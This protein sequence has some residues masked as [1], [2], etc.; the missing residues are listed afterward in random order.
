MNTQSQ[1]VTLAQAIAEENT[2]SQSVADT[3]VK[4]ADDIMEMLP[5]DLF[6]EV[7]ATPVFILHD[8]EPIQVEGKKALVY[9]DNPNEIISV[10]GSKYRVVQNEEIYAPFCESVIESDLDLE[11][12]MINS[13]F[14]DGGRTLTQLTFPQH[15]VE[16]KDEDKTALQIVTRNSHDGSW[17]FQ[18][19]TGGFRI[20]CANGQVYGDFIN[21]Y[22][23]THTNGFDISSMVDHLTRQ[24]ETF[25]NIGEYWL[26]LQGQTIDQDKA[27]DMILHYLGKKIKDKQAKE[28]ILASERAKTVRGLVESW[29]NY[30]EEMGSNMFAIYNTLTDD[31]SH[32]KADN[33]SVI[34]DSQKRLLK[35]MKEFS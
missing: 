9:A 2:M 29:G 34:F 30:K 26:T 32:K 18:V 8:E 13:S 17:K 27:T 15:M 25:Q 35:T 16:M 3:S 10:V 5:K 31:A 11:G 6:R 33:P 14:G 28:K 20:A 12:L 4:N 21:A 1:E 22:G 19:D 24:I 7:E 23:S